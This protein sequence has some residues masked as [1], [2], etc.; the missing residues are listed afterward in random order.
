M[1]VRYPDLLDTYLTAGGLCHPA[2]NFGAVLAVAEHVGATRSRLPAGPG[3]RLRGAMPVQRTGSRHG[4]RAQ[5]R[6]AAGDVGRRR[7]GEAARARRRA[8][9]QRHRRLRDR[10]RVAGRGAR[11]AGVELEGHLAGHHRHARG[12]HDDAGRP[13]RHR[14][15]V[16]VRR[17]ARPGAALRSAHRFPHRRPRAHLRRADLP[18]AVLLTDPRPG[19]HRRDLGHPRPTATSPATTSHG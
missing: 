12:L 9:R 16:V 7:H 11:R 8:H 4:A 6:T 13:R 2:D 5:S 10:Q 1:L 18:Q 15:Q 14:A 17:P 19:R 3:G